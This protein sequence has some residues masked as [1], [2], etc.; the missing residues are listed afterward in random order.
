M[1]R[2]F[3][4]SIA[5]AGV[6]LIFGLAL[7]AGL[8]WLE[9]K[10]EEELSRTVQTQGDNEIFVIETGQS[11]RQL[12]DRLTEK[13]W[14][15]RPE[16]LLLHARWAGW[17][18]RIQAGTY[19]VYS[20]ESVQSLIDKFVAGKVKTYQITFVEGSSFS[21][22][23]DELTRHGDIVQTLTNDTPADIMRELKA[24]GDHPE[25][26]FFPSTYFYVAATQDIVILRRAYLR[27]NEILDAAWQRRDPNVPYSGAY[28]ALIMAS[29]I[30]KETGRA[31]ERRDIAG[32]FVRRLNLGMKLQTDPTVIYGLGDNFDGNIRRADLTSDTPYNTYTRHG[33]P[34]TPIAMPGKAAIEAALHPNP[35]KA[36]YFVAKGDGTH[37]FSATLSAHNAAVRRYQLKH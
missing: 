2:R 19:A 18:R 28:E 22:M 21:Q 12:A 16:Y 37:Q 30:E 7:A 9:Q 26:R 14:I 15:S 24:P 17:A 32:V 20:G 5:I 1:R 6:V 13:G 25:G 10:I 27:M 36:L 35:G 23:L 29:I 34:P 4:Y 31:L 3:K 33:L 11:L 8:W